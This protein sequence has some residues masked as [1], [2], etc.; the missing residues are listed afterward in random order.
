VSKIVE[1]S[2]PADTG[3]K[4]G[5]E[6]E[7]NSMLCALTV[8]KLKPGAMEDFKQAFIPVG[9]AEAPPG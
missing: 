2:P 1:A 3:R 7:E 6:R 8:R 5:V 4:T 9:D